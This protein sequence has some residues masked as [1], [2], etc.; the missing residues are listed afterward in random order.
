[1]IAIFFS[2]SFSEMLAI[3]SIFHQTIVIKKKE[4]TNAERVATRIAETLEWQTRKE[5]VLRVRN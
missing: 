3:L 4:K 5:S 1:M 2:T